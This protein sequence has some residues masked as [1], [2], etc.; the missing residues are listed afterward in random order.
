LFGLGIK[1]YHKKAYFFCFFMKL[2][3][4]GLL[5]SH[6]VSDFVLLTGVNRKFCRQKG[7]TSGNC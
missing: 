6:R 4:I 3:Y 1:Q 2:F 7:T 5:K